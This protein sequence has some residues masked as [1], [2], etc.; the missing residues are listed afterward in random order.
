MKQHVIES[1]IPAK[2]GFS[3]YDILVCSI[4]APK[5]KCNRYQMITIWPIIPFNFNSGFLLQILFP[6]NT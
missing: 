3:V 1:K 5:A 2:N 6:P 4:A